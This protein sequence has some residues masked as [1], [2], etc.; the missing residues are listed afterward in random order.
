MWIYNPKVNQV[1]KLPP[2]MMSQSWQGSDFSNNDLAK[3]DTILEDYTHQLIGTETI[4]N[5]TAYVI[6]SIPKPEAA[7]VWGMLKLYI[8]KDMILIREEFYDEDLKP[9]KI[10]TIEKIGMMGGKLYPLQWKM[11]KADA[12]DAYTR[13]DYESLDFS[14]KLPDRLF[15]ISSLQEPR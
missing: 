11:A 12:K 3:S 6:K 10:M 5:M 8:R 14:V 7:V 15:T 9:V 4:D 2:S 13:I 1:I